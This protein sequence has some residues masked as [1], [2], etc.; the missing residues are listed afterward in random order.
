MEWNKAEL[1]DF[2]GG[3]VNDLHE[4]TPSRIQIDKG[5]DER[6][7][8]LR[9]VVVPD[10]NQVSLSIADSAN[11][12]HSS[13][14]IRKCLSI[15]TVSFFNRNEDLCKNLGIHFARGDAFEKSVVTVGTSRSFFVTVD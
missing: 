4:Y 5:P 1:C 11:V 10:K 2:V 12:I 8:H 7:N 14:E 15:E 13:I 9:M 6:D 3:T